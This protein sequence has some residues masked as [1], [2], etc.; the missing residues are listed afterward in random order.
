MQSQKII[1]ALKGAP[2]LLFLF[3]FLHT[4]AQINSPYSRYGLG[5]F[6]NSRNVVNKGMGNISTAFAD[7]Q[8]VN[9]NNP[10]AYSRLQA[11]TFDVGAEVETRTLRNQDKLEG[12]KSGYIGYHYLALGV[13]LMKDKKGMT[14]WGM[15]LG[16]RPITRINYK[17]EQKEL[18]PG[19]DSA[20]TLFQGNGG[21]NKAFLGTG[22]RVKG[23]SVG[24]NLGY[25]F[26]QQDISTQR[27]FL[28]DSVSY[29]QA[30]YQNKTSFNKFFIDGGL[31][32][33][34]KT[35]KESLI[36][37]GATGFLGQKVKATSDIRRETILYNETG[38]FDSLDVALDQ[39]DVKGTIQMPAGYSVGFL[40][41]K[42]GSWILSAEYE[43]VNWSDYRFF[44]KSDLLAN[45][46]MFRV[47]GQFTPSG[48]PKRY[49]NRIIY[50]AGFYSGKDYV[51]PTGGQ[52]PVWAGSFGLGLP[53]RRWN[54]YSNQFTIINTAF[55]LGK[56]GN[57]NNPLSENFFK[58][59]IG[60]CL[61]D[62]WFT[63]RKFD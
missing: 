49:L 32:Y 3:T 58:L 51:N 2:F 30:N 50:R 10:A 24:I 25:Y 1:Q 35:G 54:A 17:I 43:K 11:V 40:F 59:S 19:I 28:N 55:E 42:T 23:L 60:L 37:L 61:S 56:R 12:Y 31:Q 26:G 36:R 13:P 52:L 22:F 7:Y 21:S 46:S 38:S 20:S 16:I 47:G 41:Q 39:T 63:K 27:S 33:E 5:D 62:I 4:E 44:G 9:F 6:Y 8:A 48:D 45:T 15:A 14:T 34:I 18:L 53:I 29:F 57:N